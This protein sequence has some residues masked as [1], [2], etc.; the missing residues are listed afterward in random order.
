MLSLFQAGALVTND[1]LY[2]FFRFLSGSCQQ[3]LILVVFT[4]TVETVGARFR[5]SV[6]NLHFIAFSA[7]SLLVSLYLGCALF[8]VGTKLK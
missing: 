4:L 1:G 7:G 3:S 2:A 8:F 5:G 6:A